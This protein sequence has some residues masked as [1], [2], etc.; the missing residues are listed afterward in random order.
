MKH[1]ILFIIASVYSIMITS[2]VSRPVINTKDLDDLNFL[3]D[4]YYTANYDYPS[5]KDAFFSFCE[6][7]DYS[8][9]KLNDSFEVLIDFLKNQNQYIWV[10]DDSKFPNQHFSIINGR[11]T[12]IHRLNSWR[13]PC[14]GFYNDAYVESYL[15]EPPSLQEFLLFCNYCDSLTDYEN[16]PYRICD[17]ITMLN[18]HKCLYIDN[19][20]W[21][22]EK[23]IL[24]MIIDN[25]TIWRHHS[26]SPC[27]N[28]KDSMMI[29]P[30]FYD[31]NGSYIKTTDDFNYKFIHDIR[32]L[33][34]QFTNQPI[35]DLSQFHC[36]E[37]CYGK[38]SSPYCENDEI[39]LDSKWVH[40]LEEY[41]ES[42]CI[43]NELGNIIFMVPILIID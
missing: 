12:L 14:I 31:I 1:F 17:S 20:K 10:L 22:R 7:D 4:R 30:H 23:D 29:N 33:I 16:W 40:S 3:L 21:H 43:E 27:T 36:I 5:S 39:N 42:F 37:Y 26:S 38:G 34:N 9:E 11:D 24:L 2:C 41:L 32:K 6:T 19:F 28:N 13:F 8:K 18:L 35:I 25:D 15:S